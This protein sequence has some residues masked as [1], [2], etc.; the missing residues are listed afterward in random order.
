MAGGGGVHRCARPPICFLVPRESVPPPDKPSRSLVEGEWGGVCGVN[1][2]GSGPRAGHPVR[3]LPPWASR[4]EIRVEIPAQ[5]RLGERG[6][7]RGVFHLF[8]GV[9][10]GRPSWQPSSLLEIARSPPSISAMGIVLSGSASR[11]RKPSLAPV[12]SLRLV[13]SLASIDAEKLLCLA[14][15]LFRGP[16]FKNFWAPMAATHHHRH[17][18]SS[19]WKSRL[20]EGAPSFDGSIARHRVACFPY[21]R[22]RTFSVSGRFF[23]PRPWFKKMTRQRWGSSSKQNFCLRAI[24]SLPSTYFFVI[25]NLLGPPFFLVRKAPW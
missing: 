12:R 2:I 4:I 11:G 18:G 19:S 5:P 3:F 23:V 7:G 13:A 17:G 8:V 24:L 15:F 9:W 10:K 25:K 22:R 16:C 14:G 6:G 21:F 1:G 20:R